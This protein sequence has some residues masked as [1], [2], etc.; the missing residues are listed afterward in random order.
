SDRPKG[1]GW[2]IAGKF[3][4][5]HKAGAVAAGVALLSLVAA[6]GVSSWQAHIASIE[7]NKAEQRFNDVR[8]LAHSMLYELHGEIQQLPGSTRARSLLLTRSL[9][10]LDNLART[11]EGNVPLQME[12]AEAYQRIGELQSANL[13]QTKEAL[14]G[15]GQAVTILERV[16]RHNPDD[17]AA[18]LRLA[19][20]YSRF[21]RL[22][23]AT[24]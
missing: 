1:H 14:H 3:L 5:R 17:V 7:R 8:R 10:Y 20:A 19:G 4:S 13:G 15:Q 23:A 22:L 6:T 18:R 24:G 11:A 2:Y 16:V 21:G 9:E 12:L